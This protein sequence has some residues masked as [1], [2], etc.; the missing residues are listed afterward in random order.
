MILYITEQQEIGLNS[1]TLLGLAM[2]GTN[3]IK[4]Q[5]IDL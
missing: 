1:V 3:D 4:V 2:F 5:L